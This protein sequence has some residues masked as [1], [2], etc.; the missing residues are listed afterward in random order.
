MSEFYNN[1]VSTNGDAP[2]LQVVH[3]ILQYF[4]GI[5]KRRLSLQKFGELTSDICL[6]A[7]IESP[8]KKISDFFEVISQHGRTR[9]NL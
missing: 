7:V 1:N 9:D 4:K 8:L 5:P 3:R 2:N 6:D